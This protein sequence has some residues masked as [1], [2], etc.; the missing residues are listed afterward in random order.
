MGLK[1]LTEGEL[2]AELKRGG[3]GKG[4]G[5]GWYAYGCQSKDHWTFRRKVL[6]RILSM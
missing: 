3:L 2:T 6:T 4:L 1:K 5:M